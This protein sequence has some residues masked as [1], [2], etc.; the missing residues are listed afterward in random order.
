MG[1]SGPTADGTAVAAAEGDTTDQNAHAKLDP[2][3][4]VAENIGEA[5]WLRFR[6]LTS[7][8]LCR[9]MIEARAPKL[10]PA[11]AEQKGQEVASSVRGALGY[12][13]TQPGSLNAKVL[14]RYYALLQ[15]SIA[16]QISDPAST[17]DL[18]KIQSH[19]ESGHGLW[20]IAAPEEEFPANYRIACQARGHFY[21]YCR[22]KGIDLAPY[23]LGARPA[24]WAK[25]AEDKRSRTTA[26]AD[27]LRRIPELQP[28][29]EETL[30]VQPLSFR[31]GYD[32]RSPDN[33]QRGAQ[34]ASDAPRKEGP[35]TA[36]I[37]IYSLGQKLS[38]EYLRSLELPFK[39]IREDSA[40]GPQSNNFLA[41]FEHP[42]KIYWENYLGTYKS[43]YCG[44]SVIVPVWGVKDIFIIHFIVLYALS[45][46]VRYLPSLWHEIEDGRLDHIRALI[47]QYLA[48][49][50][51]VL[52][53]VAIQRI[54][55]RRLITVPPGLLHSPIIIE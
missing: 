9:R 27:M 49:V 17:A 4:L 33:A 2:E 29:I 6:R 12:W 31:V 55:G 48:V 46:V 42:R 11:V 22:Y 1:S 23:A 28:L 54:T 25:L 50:D 13:G 24:S 47:E 39:N 7:S 38:V 45:I 44:T 37:G 52:P 14:S 15:V 10:P 32:T 35:V 26:L 16:E 41:D 30:G 18:R 43:G 51:N 3:Q 34:A 21:E 8:T 5:V 40:T 36:F 20:A 53:I 19:T